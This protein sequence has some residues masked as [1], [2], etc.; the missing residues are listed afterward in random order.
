M[1]DFKKYNNCWEARNKLYIAITST[2]NKI[3]EPKRLKNAPQNIW[4]IYENMKLF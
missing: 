2:F 3:K 4:V 1:T